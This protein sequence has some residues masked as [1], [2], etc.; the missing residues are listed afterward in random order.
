MMQV[1]RVMEGQGGPEK[2]L[3]SPLGIWNAH[4]GADKPENSGPHFLQH[5]PSRRLWHLL[6]SYHVTAELLRAQGPVSS[7]SFFVV[8]SRRPRPPVAHKAYPIAECVLQITRLVLVY[9]KSGNVQSEE[10]EKNP[11][12]VRI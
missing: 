8:L 3:L 6:S 10:E 2:I 9:S 7:R 1:A 5:R 4:G 12:E 11:L